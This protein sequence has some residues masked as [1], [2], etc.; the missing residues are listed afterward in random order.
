M[1]QEDQ[2]E[3]E[4]IRMQGI[5]SII[6][7]LRHHASWRVQ[8]QEEYCWLIVS[9]DSVYVCRLQEAFVAKCIFYL[10]SVLAKTPTRENL[11][12]DPA[13]CSHHYTST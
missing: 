1:R 11:L 4:Y 10:L 13:W 7:S 5:V 8:Q 2:R 6:P 9:Q 3:S 12:Y